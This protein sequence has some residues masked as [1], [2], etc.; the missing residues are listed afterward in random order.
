MRL[1]KLDNRCG[2]S[3]L[4]NNTSD[5]EETQNFFS[6]WPSIAR[7]VGVPSNS[8]KY[9]AVVQMGLLLQNLYSSYQ[10]QDPRPQCAK[11]AENYRKHRVKP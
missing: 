4:Y 10:P 3:V 8:P 11:F 7:I 6:T 2:W 5:G 1:E 9:S